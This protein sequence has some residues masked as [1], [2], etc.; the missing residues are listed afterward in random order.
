MKHS[1]ME[2]EPILY[3]HN[4]VVFPLMHTGGTNTSLKFGFLFIAI[5]L[6][7]VSCKNKEDNL[8]IR[9][10]YFIDDNASVY[11]CPIETEYGNRAEIVVKNGDAVGKCEISYEETP[12]ICD[13]INDTILVRYEMMHTPWT[14]DTI[15][16][17]FIDY[18][19]V[20]GYVYVVKGEY[21]Y[22]YNG[23][24]VGRID[25]MYQDEGY[26][27][28]IDSV[29]NMKDSFYI[30]NGADVIYKAHQ[31]NVEWDIMS[32]RWLVSYIDSFQN[33]DGYT[34]KMREIIRFVK[35]HE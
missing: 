17:G 12:Y 18:V 27:Y 19:N 16:S 7:F 34:Y 33:D 30:Y 13:V 9:Q 29:V 32:K 21:R 11:L 22:F 31:R 3:A 5:L 26:S 8:Y 28:P 2:K 4:K 24:S 6:L 1:N 10:T 20:N 14:E 15:K 35:K 23:W 25:G